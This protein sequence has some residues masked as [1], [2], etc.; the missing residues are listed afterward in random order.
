MASN[1]D[2]LRAGATGVA[3]TGAIGAT[4]PVDFAA[5]AAAPTWNDVGYISEEGLSQAIAEDRKTWTPWGR[6]A[7]VRTQLTSSV[8]TFK[9]T[10]WE[11]NQTVL[12]LYYKQ[13]AADLA[14][15]VTTDVIDFT[16]ANA[17]NQDRRAF[18]FE[19]TDGANNLI[20]HAVPI[21]EV[22]GRG[23]IVN[24][25]DE[26]ITYELTITAYPGSDGVSVHSYFKLAGIEG[27]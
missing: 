14:P 25:T 13:A 15:D 11:T 2:F 5:P 12:G 27:A 17:L 4:F 1:A 18:L 19:V 26:L 9:V 8:K 23:D 24:R 22:T 21:G 20:R 7:P 16:D 10:C 6:T 3:W